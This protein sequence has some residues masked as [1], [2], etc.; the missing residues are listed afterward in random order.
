M[1]LVDP[2]YFDGK[3][4]ARIYI[5]G[6]LAEAK[7]VEQTLTDVGIDYA[8]DAEPFERLILGVFPSK[9]EGLAFYVLAGQAAFCRRA[10]LDAGLQM[11]IVDDDQQ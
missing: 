7:Q 8:I 2:E 1:A 11:G 9:H 10:L 5:A 6:R 4:V 3:D